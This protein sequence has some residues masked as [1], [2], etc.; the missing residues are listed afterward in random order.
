[1][2][3]IDFCIT[4]DN[5]VGLFNR[6]VN[7]IYHSTYGAY[8]ESLNKFIKPSEISLLKNKKEI[9]LLD[10]CYG[11]G[12]NSK[13]L[14]DEMQKNNININLNIDAL[15]IDKNLI[16]ISPFIKAEQYNELTNII[17][18]KNVIENF[19][20]EYIDFINLIKSEESLKNYLSF[21]LLDNQE[22]LLHNIYYQYISKSEKNRLKYNKIT[23]FSMRFFVDDARKYNTDKKYDLIYLDAFTPIK[24]PILWSYQFFKKLYNFLANDGKLITYSSSAAIRNTMI[25][26]GFSIGKI[27]DNNNNNNKS[28]GTIGVKDPSLIENQLDNFDLGLL[29]TSAGVMFQDPE[30]NL[31]N[32]EILFNRNKFIK[33]NKVQSTSSY[34]KSFNKSKNLL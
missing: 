10:I 31:T 16:F 27:V 17:I 2:K 30:L 4:E 21:D 25:K 1:M 9:N 7:D 23:N 14:I 15:E 18:L 19:K 13:T 24:T 32:E 34:I 3:N 26:V 28:I 5:S 8:T 33:E 29:N 6:E 22:G 12:Y 11:I 20:T